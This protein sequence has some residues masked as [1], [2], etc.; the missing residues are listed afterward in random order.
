MKVAINSDYGGFNLSDKAIR[1]LFELKGWKCVE[2]DTKYSFTIFYK[3]SVSEDNLFLVH[4]LE[5]NDVELIKVIEELGK[6]AS[7]LY[8][9]LKIIEIPD[10]VKW[11]IAEY[12][13]R[14]HIAENHR[15][16]R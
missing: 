11:H 15:I 16:W 9:S 14:E 10:D 13:G 12:G 7:G 1:R 5:R 3:D 6:D 4:D 2:E 8:S